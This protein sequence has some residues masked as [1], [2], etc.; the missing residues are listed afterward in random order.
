MRRGLGEGTTRRQPRPASSLTTQPCSA[1]SFFA[2]ASSMWE[3]IGLLGSWKAGSAKSTR[4]S[5]TT[6]TGSRLIPRF[7][8]S[9]RKAR[10]NM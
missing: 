8:N 1:A 5:V 7:L 4:V 2:R 3:P 10:T 6:A 9:L